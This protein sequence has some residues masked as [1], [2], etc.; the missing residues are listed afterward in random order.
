MTSY[1]ICIHTFSL[2]RTVSEIYDFLKYLT[3]ECVLNVHVNVHWNNSA[4]FFGSPPPPPPPPLP[5][6]KAGWAFTVN[7]SGIKKKIL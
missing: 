3:F 6:N 5:S 7:C 4:P 2:S 1:L